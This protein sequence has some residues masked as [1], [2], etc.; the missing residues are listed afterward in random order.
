MS[1][2]VNVTEPSNTAR[3]QQH[4]PE[5]PATLQ[6]A[7][8]A[9]ADPNKKRP[10]IAP[11]GKVSGAPCAPQSLVYLKAVTAI[12]MRLSAAINWDPT[13]A[14]AGGSVLNTRT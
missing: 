14:R 3:L 6:I 9:S 10:A 12:S 13:V 1:V 7:Q 11:D 2:N 4:L 8:P 5:S